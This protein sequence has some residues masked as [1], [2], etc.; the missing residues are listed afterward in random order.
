MDADD[1]R[2][3]A[4]ALPEAAES[5]HFGKADFRVRNRIFASLPEASRGVVKLTPDEQEMLAGAEPGIFS[6]VTGGWGRK[7]WTSVDLA[8][9]DAPTL[10]GAL[11]LAWRNAA[12]KSLVKRMDAGTP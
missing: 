2:R 6:A 1:L 7:G 8:A 3:T 5:A 11:R 9:I 12:P 10:E 4:L